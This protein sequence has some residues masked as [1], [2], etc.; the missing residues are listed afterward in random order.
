MACDWEQEAKALLQQ[1]VKMWVCHGNFGPAK[2]LVRG[3]KI[4][5]KLVRRTIIFRKYWSAR[6]IMVRAQ[7]LRCKHFND[8][9]LC[10]SICIVSKSLKKSFGKQNKLLKRLSLCK[11]WLVCFI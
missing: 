10:Q 2:I 4:R 1:V 6:G 7:I 5:G 8:T 3:T 11:Y 9:S